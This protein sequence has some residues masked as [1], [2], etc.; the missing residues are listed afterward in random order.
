MPLCNDK[1]RGKVFKETRDYVMA[2]RKLTS[3]QA[4]YQKERRRLL[5]AVRRGTKKGLQF[6]SDIVPRLPKR[7]TRKALEEIKATRPSALYESAIIHMKQAQETQETRQ[8]NTKN[9]DY[10]R[11][12]QQKYTE[13]LYIKH[14]RIAQEHDYKYPSKYS[15]LTKEEKHI[16]AIERGKKA[17][18]TRRSKMSDKEYQD[19]ISQFK[20][21]MK[22]SREKKLKGQR[23]AQEDYPILDIFELAKDKIN[24][25]MQTY[26]NLTE[27]TREAIEQLPDKNAKG[28]RIGARRD[29]LLS[30][31]DDT[32]NEAE[33]EDSL[34]ELE[35]YLQENSY[36]I[37][38]GLELIVLSSDQ[39]II[40]N[41][42]T[43]LARVLN[44][45]ALNLQQAESMSAMA[46]YMT[47]E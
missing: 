2:K 11:H 9:D 13:E 15:K 35:E 40:D 26:G 42:F 25:L 5:Q 20:E 22:Q 3:A 10:I 38:E 33:Q 4:E 7:V 14:P 34:D 17:W 37:N 31:Y 8:R 46:E 16:R 47:E 29:S 18:K 43:V 19:Y 45:G 30:I 44:Q 1:Y 32:Y 12:P 6:P 41:H 28:W 24:N 23:Q 21:R 27:T 39:N 36:T